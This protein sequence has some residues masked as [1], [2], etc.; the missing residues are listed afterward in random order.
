[1]LL[2]LGQ[3]GKHVVSHRISAVPRAPRAKND[4]C[5]VHFHLSTSRISISR[6]ASTKQG[7]VGES[8]RADGGGAAN[9]RPFEAAERHG[10]EGW[11]VER[12]TGCRRGLAGRRR[13]LA[14]GGS[15]VAGMRGRDVP[16]SGGRVRR[17]S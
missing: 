13:G 9:L 4:Q 1:M 3:L 11:P 6:A 16:T 12:F 14:V 10:T 17:G 8:S 7:R 2:K 5:R 15:G